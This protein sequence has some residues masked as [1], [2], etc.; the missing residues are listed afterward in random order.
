MFVASTEPS[1]R[2]PSGCRRHAVATRG[3]WWPGLR[4]TDF[5][6]PIATPQD[7]I[8]RRSREHGARGRRKEGRGDVGADAQNDS[9]DR[10]DVSRL[11]V[12]GFQRGRPEHRRS[13]IAKGREHIP[14]EQLELSTRFV[15]AR[16]ETPRDPCIA[17]V[18][19][20]GVAYG[21]HTTKLA[22]TKRALG[23]SEC[24]QLDRVRAHPRLAAP[25]CTRTAPTPSWSD[26][27]RNCRRKRCAHTFPS[28]KRAFRISR[29]APPCAV[30]VVAPWA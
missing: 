24:A 1:T 23:R 20:S 5:D 9:G 15:P 28:P 26:R 17:V 8:C 16:L 27:S 11:V 6:G 13:R 29:T 25:V 10:R 14:L 3:L 12:Q 18:R 22:A 2:F 30:R 4:N 19:G 7:S 21:A